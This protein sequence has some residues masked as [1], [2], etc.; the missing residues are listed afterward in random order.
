MTM[1]KILFSILTIG[2]SLV[3]CTNLEEVSSEYYGEGPS[4]T[5][6]VTAT[7]DESFTFVLTPSEGTLYYSYLVAEGDEAEEVD[8]LSLL[9]NQ[10]SG[11][12]TDCIEYAE[13][14]TYTYDM[15]DEE[16]KELCSP[17]TS[18]VLYAVAA[19]KEGIAGKVTS[20][21]VKTTDKVNP[22]FDLENIEDVGGESGVV[23]PFSENVTLAENK[24]VT[25]QYYVE[26]ATSDNFVDIPAEDISVDIDGS[27]VSITVQNVPAA[28]IV[29]V[30]WEEGTFVDSYGNKCASLDSGLNVEGNGFDG[31]YFVIASEPF[32]ITEENVVTGA[33]EDEE[34]ELPLIWDETKG[35]SLTFEDE[36][37]RNGGKLKGG[38]I[39]L[40]I[41][42]T[43]KE[44]I[45]D[46]GKDDWFIS[47]N[48]K[49]LT[50]K[51]PAGESQ[52]GDIISLKIN[53]G[54][55]MD[56]NGNPNKE[57]LIE[58]YWMWP[59]GYTT[60]K[61]SYTLKAISNSNNQEVSENLIVSTV[62]DE[63]SI[64]GFLG[65]N[66]EV[67]GTLDSDRG[68]IYIKP[69]YIAQLQLPI[70]EEGTM[71]TFNLSVEGYETEGYVLILKLDSEGNLSIANNIIVFGLYDSE[72]E[73]YDMYD[74][75][76]KCK[77][78]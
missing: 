75:Y 19:N 57:C 73:Y 24:T 52:G 10:L 77:F 60:V 1:K 23:V 40:V 2:A 59:L 61:S 3:G 54:A 35:I 62:G 51:M 71:E 14:A 53:E 43:G 12:V 17:N 63:I 16:G 36:I 38:E 27:N 6:E 48:K 28:A 31:L 4:I 11:V 47:E 7:A 50:V 68:E 49:S 67:K 5:A 13:N 26:W 66:K 34:V 69:Q 65:T 72:D 41:K 55:I 30:S 39:Q 64:K 58:D 37:Y 32:E 29:L 45:L 76:I 78:E 33:A 56:I 25:A 9:Q 22:T 15:K 20:V 21:V 18:Y 74:A 8:A 44:I 46:L 42:R 70:D